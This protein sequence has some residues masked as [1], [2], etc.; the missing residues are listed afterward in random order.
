M[1]H[2]RLFA[3]LI[4]IT[5]VALTSTAS[6]SSPID[7]EAALGQSFDVLV[8][9]AQQ[10]FEDGD[11]DAAIEYLIIAKY[12]QPE[13]ALLLNIARSYE[14][15]GDCRRQLAYYR[16][17]LD[18]PPDDDALIERAERAIADSADDCEDF[19]EEMTGRLSFDSTPQLA[20]VYIDGESYGTTPTD[21]AGLEPGV[22]TVRLERDGY[23]DYT[24][25]LD[26]NPAASN[27][28]FSIELQQREDDQ[29][30][31]AAPTEEPLLDDEAAA[32]ADDDD[33]PD[34]SFQL[35]PVA[36]GMLGGGVASLATGAALD[37]FVI[38]GIDDRRSDAREQ[39]DDDR[40]DELTQQRETAAI[41][42]L[43]GYIVG[44][45]LT[46][47]SL[48]WIGYDYYH[49]RERQQQES[50]PQFGWQITGQFHRDGGGIMIFGRF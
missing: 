5:L 34:D 13:P 38:P 12:Q 45:L 20:T 39:G 17:F 7:K 31:A 9:N 48:A 1:K 26:V 35:N 44:G 4:F 25:H 36:L 29:P 46:V 40:V 22:H 49:H 37:I 16:T 30:D 27:L 14:K 2:Q 41:A 50:P 19:D 8:Q 3:G 33:E 42:A 18:D 15:L 32:E 23:M 43:S 10:A 28:E 11:Y 21:A 24:T 47:S 6:A